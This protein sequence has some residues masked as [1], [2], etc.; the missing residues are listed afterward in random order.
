MSFHFSVVYN[1]E[2]STRN[3]NSGG[4]ARNRDMAASLSRTVA[5]L[6]GSYGGAT[7]WDFKSS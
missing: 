1:G 3:E 7:I 5:V 6:G 2:D 4:Q